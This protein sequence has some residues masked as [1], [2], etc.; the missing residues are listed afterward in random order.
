METKNRLTSS[1][2]LPTVAL[3]SLFIVVTILCIVAPGVHSNVNMCFIVHS[4]KGGN[5]YLEG[6]IYKHDPR[7]KPIIE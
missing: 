1:N 4:K 5:V 7:A 3:Y 2:P 6:R